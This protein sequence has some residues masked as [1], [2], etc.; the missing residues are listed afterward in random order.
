MAAAYPDRSEDPDAAGGTAA[1]PRRILFLCNDGFYFRQH[2]QHLALR[3][4]DDGWDVHVGTGGDIGE[5]DERLTFHRLTVER[6]R[7][8]P[9]ADL[10]LTRQIRGLVRT[11]RPDI[12]HAMTMKP[13]VVTALALSPL[14]APRPAPRRIVLTF[15]G[16]GR[17]F[18]DFSV[19]GHARR[20]LVEFTLARFLAN[21][22]ARATFE[23]ASDRAYFVDQGIAPAEHAV[24]VTGAGLDLDDFA[25]S[26]ERPDHAP[27]RLRVL[28]ASRFIRGKG[29][30]AFVEAAEKARAAGADAEFLVAGYADPGHADRLTQAEIDAVAAN[31]AI[32][33]L[34]HVT[35]M[36]GLFEKVDALVLPS[37]YQEGLPRILIEGAAAG[38]ALIASDVP[39]CREIVEDGLTGRLLTGVS[40]DA[41]WAALRD[42]VADPADARRL[43]RAAHDLVWR[44]GFD[45]RTVQNAFIAAYGLR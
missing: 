44:R 7:L 14:V 6:W 23:N 13:A 31:P 42:L 25:A 24:L 36:P 3:M 28:W 29:L 8:S 4:A 33:F 16:L 21:P 12:V 17:I 37:Q 26:A 45:E 35:D 10:A 32:R 1:P 39:G 43:G 30:H 27:G 20:R 5:G 22:R 9:G 18:E 11:L 19:A 38:V 41:V 15:P 40:G 2:R 34:G